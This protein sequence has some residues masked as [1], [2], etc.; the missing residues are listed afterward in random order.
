MRRYDEAISYFR[1]DLQLE[2]NDIGAKLNLGLCYIASQHMSAAIDTLK[3][4]TVEKPDN[5]FANKWLALAYSASDSMEQAVAVYNHLIKLALADTSGADHSSDLNDAYRYIAVYQIIQAAKIQKDRPDEA[6][7][8][9][10]DAFTSLQ[11]ALKYA[12]KDTKTLAL[13][14]QDYAYMGKIDQACAEIKKV[15][16]VVSKDDPVHEQM[17]KLQKSIGCQ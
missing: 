3:M 17:I 8:L 2:P 1:K 16:N 11:S 12:P 9:Y 5:Y 14:A 15:L 4:V 7:K 10:Q 6:K 13:L